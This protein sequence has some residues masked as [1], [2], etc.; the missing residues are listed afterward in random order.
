MAT[1]ESSSALF[2]FLFVLLCY[3]VL[4]GGG[5]DCKL[6]PV[7]LGTFGKSRILGRKAM[8][9][10]SLFEGMASPNTTPHTYS[11]HGKFFF[12]LCE[13]VTF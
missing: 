2:V 11:P 12:R 13:C 10:L 6:H 9:F 5:G 7:H 4:R 1:S 3:S 8:L